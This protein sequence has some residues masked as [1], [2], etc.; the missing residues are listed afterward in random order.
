MITE[1]SIWCKHLVSGVEIEIGKYKKG[2]RNVL[3]E[4][5]YGYSINNTVIYKYEWYRRMI[6]SVEITVINTTTEPLVATPVRITSA[7]MN[8]NF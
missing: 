5:N 7:Y 2:G 4:A 8:S 1:D 3:S 6:G